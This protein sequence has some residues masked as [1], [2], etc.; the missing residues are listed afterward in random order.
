MD[1]KVIGKLFNMSLIRYF[2]QV[3]NG[4][5]LSIVLGLDIVAVFY[6]FFTAMK[7]IKITMYNRLFL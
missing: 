7:L 1:A 5:L 2:M 4:T 6:K 3:F